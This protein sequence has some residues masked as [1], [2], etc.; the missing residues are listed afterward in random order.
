M[1]KQIKR[2]RIETGTLSLPRLRAKAICCSI[3]GPPETVCLALGPGRS[4]DQ[5]HIIFLDLVFFVL[6]HFS[7]WMLILKG[8]FT[9]LPRMEKPH[10]GDDCKELTMKP[11]LRLRRPATTLAW[12]QVKAEKRLSTGAPKG[13]C[14]R[15]HSRAPSHHL[16]PLGWPCSRGAPHSNRPSPPVSQSKCD[17]HPRA[18]SGPPRSPQVCYGA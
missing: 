17:R 13:F 14:R 6:T 3:C 16:G 15:D 18:F 11:R 8:Q 5:T 1:N 10:H 7:S 4:I 2:E 12:L 9:S